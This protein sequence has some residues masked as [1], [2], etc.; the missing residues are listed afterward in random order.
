VSNSTIQRTHFNALAKRIFDV[1]FSVAGLLVL[2]PMFLV[3]AVL[4]WLCDRKTVLFRQ[5]R[6]GRGGVSFHIIKFRTMVIEADKQGASVTKAG[7]HRITPIGRVLRRFK[8][9]ELPQLW[10]VL[11]GEMSFVGPRPE[12]PRYV[13]RYTPVQLELLQFKPGITDW[14]TLLFRN[15]EELL[16]EAEDPEEFYVAYCIPKKFSLNMQYAEKANVVKDVWIIVQTL[17]PHGALVLSFYASIF[18]F[19]TLISYQLSFDFS[20]PPIEWIHIGTILM[21]TVGLK[22]LLLLFR[23][24]FGGLL[25]YFS[26]REV[27][28]LFS[29]L[30]AAAAVQ[31]VFWYLSDG[32]V[33]LPRTVIV[34]DFLTSMFLVGMIRFGLRSLREQGIEVDIG[35]SQTGLKRVGIIGAG[36]FG[37]SLAK[38]FLDDPSLGI[39]VDGF[40]DDLPQR[41]HRLIHGVRVLGMPETLENKEWNE[42]LDEVIIAMPEAS[43]ERLQEILDMLRATRL[44]YYIVP[45]VRQIRDGDIVIS[46]LEA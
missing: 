2:L 19:S 16:R 12:V 20:V 13:E 36:T 31:F 8:L 26:R 30:T 25:S 4:I 34:I 44:K 21:W 24:D 39:R 5:L 3:I 1:S 35:E 23:A 15:E 9:D 27:F 46:H 22:V 29:V 43:V 32:K 38:Q 41:W 7:D 14:A 42:K 40:F 45:S 28:Q 37:A 17:V 6:V 33:S 11:K 18:V 10:N